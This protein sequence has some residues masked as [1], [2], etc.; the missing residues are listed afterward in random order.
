MKF[1][2]NFNE[3]FK[4]NTSN[5][6]NTHIFNDSYGSS[7]RRWLDEEVSVAIS[8]AVDEWV[9]TLTE[10]EQVDFALGGYN[11]ISDEN[12]WDD[13]YNTPSYKRM[14]SRVLDGDLDYMFEVCQEDGW[15][16]EM[17]S[18][19]YRLDITDIDALKNFYRDY[20][21]GL[22]ADTINW[23]GIEGDVWDYYIDIKQQELE[24][25]L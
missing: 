1:Y 11:W 13:L 4:S 22:V 23:I 7:A 12:R 16:Q 3:M 6:N 20:K 25:E 21:R 2:N 24:N 19:Y 5:I 14:E 18:D 9:D 10:D 17:A 15:V 8:E